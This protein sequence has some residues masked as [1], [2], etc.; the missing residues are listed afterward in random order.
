[1]LDQAWVKQVYYRQWLKGISSK[2]SYSETTFS[3]LIYKDYYD[4]QDKYYDRLNGGK[5]PAEQKS[6]TDGAM[7][8]LPISDKET[9]GQSL[10]DLKNEV[11]AQK[12]KIG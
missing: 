8:D 6:S 2:I 10:N 1:M 4:I 3:N 9:Q 5:K 12:Q 11:L 7:I